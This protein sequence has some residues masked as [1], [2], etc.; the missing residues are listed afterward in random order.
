MDT[1]KARENWS[2]IGFEERFLLEEVPHVTSVAQL[3]SPSSVY[4][5]IGNEYLRRETEGERERGRAVYGS[6]RDFPWVTTE[7]CLLENGEGKK[8]DFSSSCRA[9][10][11]KEESTQ[12]DDRTCVLTVRS[13]TKGHH[14]ALTTTDMTRNGGTSTGILSRK[15]S[16]D[17]G[18]RGCVL[19]RGRGM[20]S[21]LARYIHPSIRSSFSRLWLFFFIPSLLVVR[22]RFVSIG[23]LS[24]F[25][26]TFNPCNA[27]RNA[28]LF[29][30][31][32]IC[33]P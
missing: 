3:T 19:V 15:Y 20:S 7:P 14:Y 31:L 24:L 18:K 25:R 4:N 32:V 27:T 11:K 16:V 1:L 6:R 28:T 22:V 2:G 26:I 8:K 10:G 23:C 17:K 30:I 29:S 13:R 33:T 5:D 9:K 21:S 12:A